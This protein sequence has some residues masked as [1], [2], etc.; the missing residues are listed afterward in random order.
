METVKLLKWQ[1]CHEE[2]NNQIVFYL[3]GTAERHPKL[4]RNAVLAFTSSVVDFNI[5]RDNKIVTFETRNTKYVCDFKFFDTTE[6]QTVISKQK[7]M[8]TKTRE[9][10]NFSNECVAF[11]Q[12]VKLR[13][14]SEAVGKKEFED[15]FKLLT[16][17]EKELEERKIDNNKEL[18]T[19]ASEYSNCIYMEIETISKGTNIAFNINGES[20]ILEPLNQQYVQDNIIEYSDRQRKILFKYK[21][22]G[23]IIEIHQISSNIERLVIHNSKGYEIIVDMP[24][25]SYEIASNDTLEIL[26]K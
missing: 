25:R 13:G 11:T 17:G 2:V 19:K 15:W 18:I 12:Y 16:I 9:L 1:L 5:D 6:V 3:T 21:P 14:T 4:G 10:S 8:D 22:F 23:K 26:N 20:G 7:R 24:D